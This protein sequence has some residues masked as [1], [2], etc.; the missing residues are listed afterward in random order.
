MMRG[1]AE[2]ALGF[3]FIQKP[4]CDSHPGQPVVTGS[5]GQGIFCIGASGRCMGAHESHIRCLPARDS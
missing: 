5:A 2:T 4:D 1:R 3:G